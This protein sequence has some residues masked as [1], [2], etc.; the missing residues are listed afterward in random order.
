VVAAFEIDDYARWRLMEGLDDI[1]LSL[2]H[3]DDIASFEARRPSW[4]P[5]TV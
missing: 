3:A 5:L 4:M 1:A 2:T